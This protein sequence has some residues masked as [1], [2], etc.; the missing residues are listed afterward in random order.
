MSQEE[1]LNKYTKLNNLF[2]RKTVFH[3]GVNA[4]FF[5]EYN[6]MILAVLYCL[7]H[8]LKFELYSKDANFGFEK[9]WEDYF[10]PF[11]KTQTNDFHS[12][13][14]YRFVTRFTDKEKRK[15]KIF[16]LLHFTRYFTQDLWYHMHKELWENVEDKWGKKYVIP[17]LGIEGNLNEV[18]RSLVRMT[19][20]YNKS[21]QDEISNMIQSLNL[22]DQY[23]GFHIRQG[24]KFVENTLLSPDKYI[25]TAMKEFNIH[26]AFILT[27]DY[28]VIEELRSKY[29]D[30]NIYTLCTE[31][32]RG[33]FYEDFQK[34]N[35][36]QVK[37][38]SHLRLF[39]S[40]DIIA[41]SQCF[42]GTFTSNPG[43]YLGMRMP[44][45]KCRGL[46]TETWIWR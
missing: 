11:C 33:Y 31:E 37:R 28:T 17:E 25:E 8:K 35:D 34:Q 16:K 12:Y 2:L 29:Q 43:M 7:L 27:D 18:C 22:P 30:W 23:L 6:N 19:W 21:T 44:L 1:L 14:N 15:I 42:Y 3:V 32:E 24:D 45:N 40:M 20:R 36:K 26:S 10:E 4:G 5:S 46:D 38:S 39:A 9:G 13:Y 41:R